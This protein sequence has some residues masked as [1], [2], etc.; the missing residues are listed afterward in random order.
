MPTVNGTPDNC[1]LV[2][3]P[4]PSDLARNAGNGGNTIT[5]FEQ[6]IDI[7]DLTA[8]ASVSPI[9]ISTV[10][11][12]VRISGERHTN[13]YCRESSS[14]RLGPWRL[15]PMTPSRSPGLPPV[16]EVGRAFP[17]RQMR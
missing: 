2:Q 12:D 1:F 5:H 11:T 8:M 16:S 3:C 17:V 7:I 4:D 10:A 6:G 14:G 13:R 9:V 15:Q